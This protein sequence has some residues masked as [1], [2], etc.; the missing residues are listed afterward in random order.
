MFQ[1]LPTQ[2]AERMARREGGPGGRDHTGGGGGPVAT[3]HLPPSPP[4]TSLSPQL[5]QSLCG[6]RPL[7][8]HHRPPSDLQH[9]NHG[10]ERGCRLALGAGR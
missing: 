4:H 2:Q 10:K 5:R 6:H 1:T 3:P 8:P 7:P 9:R